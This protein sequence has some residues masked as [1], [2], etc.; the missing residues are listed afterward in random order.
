M[1][2]L[3]NETINKANGAASEFNNKIHGNEK[4]LDKVVQ[5][6]GEKMGEMASSF[7]HSTSDSLKTSRDFVKENPLKGVAIAAAVG[8]VTGSLITILMRSRKS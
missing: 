3:T 5:N 6:V 4:Q 7:V 1:A 8:A 2:N